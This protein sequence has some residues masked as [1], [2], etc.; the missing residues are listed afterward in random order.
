MAL[1]RRV[2]KVPQHTQQS[3]GGPGRQ[4]LLLFLSFVPSSQRLSSHQ[5]ALGQGAEQEGRKLLVLLRA[6]R[7]PGCFVRASCSPCHLAKGHHAAARDSQDL[8]LLSCVMSKQ[9]A[10]CWGLLCSALPNQFTPNLSSLLSVQ[11]CSH[12]CLWSGLCCTKTAK[13]THS[14]ISVF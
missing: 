4:G 5:P 3:P 12:C 13:D 8:L 2:Q 1:G 6:S 9:A 10:R 14:G 7:S 11:R